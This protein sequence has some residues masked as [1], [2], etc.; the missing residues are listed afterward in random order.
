MSPFLVQWKLA[1][2]AK[3][4]LCKGSIFPGFSVAR[5][6]RLPP[7]SSI[8]AVGGAGP[9]DQDGKMAVRM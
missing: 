9:Y 2:S 5:F 7:G 6:F 3:A 4:P 1:V 8:W